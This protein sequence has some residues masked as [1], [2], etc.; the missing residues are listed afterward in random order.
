MNIQAGIS[1]SRA[2]WQYSYRHGFAFAIML[3]ADDAKH[4]PTEWILEHKGMV[5]RQCLRLESF[6]FTKCFLPSF[7]PRQYS[8][9]QRL[10]GVIFKQQPM[11]FLEGIQLP[12]LVHRRTTSSPKFY[13]AQQ[14][15]V[16]CRAVLL[17]LLELEGLT[18]CWPKRSVWIAK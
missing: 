9:P 8:R 14:L 18:V 15:R 6:S 2:M 5:G 10:P 4:D 17:M 11:G 7:A 3:H 12:S 16:R 1:I 13:Q